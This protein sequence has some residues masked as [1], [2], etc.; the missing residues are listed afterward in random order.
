M[1]VLRRETGVTP[2]DCGYSVIVDLAPGAETE[3]QVHE[4][5]AR[6]IKALRAGLEG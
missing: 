4:E 5:A 1:R 2:V 3:E 6:Q